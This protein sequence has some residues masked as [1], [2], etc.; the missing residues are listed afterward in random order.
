MFGVS[1]ETC[2]NTRIISNSVVGGKINSTYK[3]SVSPGSFYFQ[4]QTAVFK[5]LSCNAGLICYDRF[6]NIDDRTEKHAW[7]PPVTFHVSL[8]Y[9]VQV[10]TVET[11]RTQL[12]IDTKKSSKKCSVIPLKSSRSF[13]PTRSDIPKLLQHYINNWSRRSQKNS[14]NFRTHATQSQQ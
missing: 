6:E 13:S 14:V 7:I 4:S 10:D 9:F 2:G 11:D 3:N 8:M 1:L 5:C 12:I